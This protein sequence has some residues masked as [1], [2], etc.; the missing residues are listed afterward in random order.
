MKQWVLILIFALG[1]IF[2]FSS[3]QAENWKEMSV[4]EREGALS[5]MTDTQLEQR[6]IELQEK[7][8]KAIENLNLPGLSEEDKIELEALTK[9]RDSRL[10]ITREKKYPLP[11]DK[12]KKQWEQEQQKI[13][14]EQKEK[15][16]LE[17]QLR[18]EISQRLSKKS[19]KWLE[20]RIKELTERKYWYVPKEVGKPDIAPI[21]PEEENELEH[22]YYE[23]DIRKEKAKVQRE[24]EA[25]IK[26]KDRIKTFSPEIQRNIKERK[27]RMGMTKEQVLLSWGYPNKVNRS[28][29][30]WGEH[31]QWCYP[32]SRYLYFENDVLTNWQD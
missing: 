9:E 14:H 16:A 7:R 8:G 30:E 26:R 1:L 19:D 3:I 24:R 32:S 22:L 28:V 20:N 31:E 11:W 29:G 6:Y 18:K 23:R 15:E 10:A 5:K 2:G 13:E 4:Q 25:P 21:T 27:I 17:N 12:V